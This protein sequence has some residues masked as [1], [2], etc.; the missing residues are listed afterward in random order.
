MGDVAAAVD[1][2]VCLYVCVSV[3]VCVS[4]CRCVPVRVVVTAGERRHCARGVALPARTN[5]AGAQ[6]AAALQMT[7]FLLWGC[8]FQKFGGVDFK[9]CCHLE[10]LKYPTPH[11]PNPLIN[12]TPS[13]PPPRGV[14]SGP[15]PGPESLDFPTP[16]LS[17]PLAGPGTGTPREGAGTSRGVEH[18]GGGVF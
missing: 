7:S 13:F 5:P 4:V 10:S 2:S 6:E 14:A 1:V 11:V 3:R 8:N 12:P 15:A 9:C 18:I 17:R 16:W